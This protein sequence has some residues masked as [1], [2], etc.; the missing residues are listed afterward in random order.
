VSGVSTSSQGVHGQSNSEAGVAGLSDTGNGV[1][2]TSTSSR[3][4]YGESTSGPGVEGSGAIGV[5]AQSSSGYAIET[6]AGGLRLAGIS[7]LADIPAGDTTFTVKVPVTVGASTLVFLT[8]E[9]DLGSKD[10]WYTKPGS[11]DS[12][13][14]HLGGK[15]SKDTRV[16]W[17][18]IDHA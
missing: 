3:G 7:G 14:I 1:H 12:F 13:I 5:R 18:V 2:G 10:L 9:S 15:R 16:A 11:S 4:V 6:T 17:L 8:P